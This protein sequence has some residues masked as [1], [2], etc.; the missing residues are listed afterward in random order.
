[1]FKM[2]TQCQYL[3][4]YAVNKAIQFDSDGST[5]PAVQKFFLLHFK[6]E[7]SMRPMIICKWNGICLPIQ[8][9]IS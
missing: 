1:M 8:S 5:T 3:Y 2:F 7:L 9:S 4:L 6:S